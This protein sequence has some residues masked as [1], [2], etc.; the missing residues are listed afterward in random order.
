MAYNS[1][2]EAAA[3]GVHPADVGADLCKDRGLL[4]DIAALTGTKAHYAVDV[5]GA[6]G[7]LAIQRASR[8]SLREVAHTNTGCRLSVCVWKFRGFL[9]NILSGCF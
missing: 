4:E 3:H 8:V 1:K 5:P 9:C 2:K 6:V 7:I